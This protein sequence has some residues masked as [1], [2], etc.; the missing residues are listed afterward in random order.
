MA[1]QKLE[2]SCGYT[3]P[4]YRKE[5]KGREEGTGVGREKT[6]YEVRLLACYIYIL[7]IY[8]PTVVSY[9]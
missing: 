6:V 4:V 8:S 1:A 5:D 7:H 3:D 2:D 9:F